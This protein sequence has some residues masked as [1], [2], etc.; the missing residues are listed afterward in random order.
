METVDAYILEYSGLPFPVAEICVSIRPV[1]DCA[2][3]WGISADVLYEDICTGKQ[4]A[5]PEERARAILED[6]HAND[7]DKWADILRA[8][9]LNSRPDCDPDYD[10]TENVYAA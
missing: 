1:E 2:F 10:T 7:D 9:R 3:R 6:I 4:H 5:M 8:A